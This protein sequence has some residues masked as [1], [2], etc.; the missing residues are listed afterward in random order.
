MSIICN[1]QTTQRVSPMPFVKWAGGKQSLAKT[2]ISYFPQ[3][4]KTY[5]EPFI[6]GGGVFFTLGHEKAVISDENKWL[7]DTYTALRDSWEDVAS[8]LDGMTNTKEDFLRYRAINPLNLGIVERAALFVYLNK[9]CFRGLFRV[10]RKGKFNVPYGAYDRRYYNPSNLQE[11]SNV[12]VD[13]KIRSC[14]FEFG[15]DGITN[16]DFV[17]FD[18]P[19]YKLG[20]YSDFNRYTGKKFIEKDHFRLAAM[21]R[22]LDKKGIRWAVSNSNTEFIRNL[23]LGFNIQTIS[24]R[25]E[26]NLKS[27]NRNI[28]DLLILNFDM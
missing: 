17:Y 21:C 10:N 5:Y 18:P 3:D 22:E 11:V 13:T 7:I 25:R 14:D 26:I 27:K 24:A 1:I 8:E 16:E 19:Y 6:G 12:L 23:Y 20:G 15:I 2:L 9:T 28:K 4:F